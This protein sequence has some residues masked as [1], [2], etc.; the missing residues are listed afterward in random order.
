MYFVLLDSWIIDL[1]AFIKVM[2]PLNNAVLS[3]GYFKK[4]P[5]YIQGLSLIRELIIHCHSPGMLGT[6]SEI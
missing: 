6:L 1:L 4:P 3:I 2:L 5:S